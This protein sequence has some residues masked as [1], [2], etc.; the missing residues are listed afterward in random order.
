MGQ[1]LLKEL[2][3]MENLNIRALVYRSMLEIKECQVFSGSLND[4]NSLKEAT[5]GVDTVVHLAAV[6]HTN[7]KEDYYRVNSIGTK[8]LIEACSKTGVERFIYVS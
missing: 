5:I 3:M 8:N 6:T 7:R 2:L 1:T 4:V